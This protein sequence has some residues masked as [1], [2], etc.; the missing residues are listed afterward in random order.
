M[1][2]RVWYVCVHKSNDAVFVL[3][4]K[5]IELRFLRRISR[6]SKERKGRFFAFFHARLIEGVNVKHRACV[7]RLQLEQEEELTEGERIEFGDPNG[8]VHSA[9]FG[10]RVSGRRVLRLNELFHRM[11]AEEGD[12]GNVFTAVRN[13]HFTSV[14]LQGKEGDDFVERTFGVELYL[15]V[16]IGRTERFDGGLT[17]VA[18]LAVEGD[19]L[20]EGF[21]PKLAIPVCKIFENLFHRRQQLPVE[22][23]GNPD[24]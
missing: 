9:R 2:L 20:A 7:R 4:G 15:R 3:C 18:G 8:I 23:A 12:V 21:R 10:E 11:T 22:T 5:G 14:L 13:G 17:N 1:I 16:L 6:F 19:V 24:Q